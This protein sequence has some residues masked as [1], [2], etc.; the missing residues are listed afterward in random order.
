MLIASF[1]GWAFTPFDHGMLSIEQRP[2]LILL[3][4]PALSP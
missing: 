1:D 4:S 2:R 3:A